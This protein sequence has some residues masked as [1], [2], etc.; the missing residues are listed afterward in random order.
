MSLKQLSIAS[1]GKELYK[2]TSLLQHMKIKNPVAKNQMIFLQRCIYHYVI[3][4]SFRLKTPVK[5]KKAFNIMNEYKKKLH[6]IAKNNAKERM[7]NA[8]LKVNELCQNLKAKVSE[9]HYLL[10]QFATEKSRENEIVKKK[11]HLIYKLNKLQSTSSKRN[12]H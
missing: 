11:E 12:N 9:E 8:A 7:F 2:Q 10:I 4:K 1:Y 6:V 5:S 3:P